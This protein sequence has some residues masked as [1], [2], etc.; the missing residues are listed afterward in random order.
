[1]EERCV[2]D[3][4]AGAPRPWLDEGTSTGRFGGDL[5]AEIGLDPSREMLNLASSRMPSA[6][7]AQCWGAP[8]PGA[9]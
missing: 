7:S 3:R 5:G 1:L 9:S 2:G 6:V 8:R 4:L